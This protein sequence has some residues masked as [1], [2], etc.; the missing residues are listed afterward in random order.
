MWKLTIEQTVAKGTVN[1]LNKVEFVDENQNNLLDLV[2]YLSEC[3]SEYPTKYS[4]ETYKES[5]D[6]SRDDR[7]WN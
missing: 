7:V 6:V 2:R 1:V 5:S 4:V 3:N